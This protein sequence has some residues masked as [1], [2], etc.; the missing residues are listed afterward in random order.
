[1][2]TSSTTGS[3][4]RH[5]PE[6]A[7]SYAEADERRQ[8]IHARLQEKLEASKGVD[9]E[10]LSLEFRRDLMILADEFG[11]WSRYLDATFDNQAG[12]PKSKAE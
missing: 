7:Y 1:M 3:T 12:A 10:L 11:R 8:Q 4:R 9:W 2:E 5:Q 6:P